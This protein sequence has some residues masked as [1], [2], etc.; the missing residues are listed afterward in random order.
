LFGV[1]IILRHTDDCGDNHG[2]EQQRPISLHDEENVSQKHLTYT[3][4]L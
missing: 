4:Y 3:V 1:F 2:N